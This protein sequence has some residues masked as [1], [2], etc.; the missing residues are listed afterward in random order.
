MTVRVVL[1]D[2]HSIVTTGLALLLAESDEV[3]VVGTATTA[4]EALDVIAATDPHV[5]LTDLSMP[6]MGGLELVRRLAAHRGG[7]RVLVLSATT[8]P[9]DL[10]SAIKGGASG[11]LVKDAPV[12]EIVAGIK[13]AAAG[14]MVV[15]SRVGAALALHLRQPEEESVL[16]E[17]EVEILTLVSLGLTN[18][19]ICQRLHLAEATVKTY[20]TRCYT[21]LDARDRASA[22]RVAIAKG[23]ID[24]T[25][26]D[27][28][29]L[30]GLRFPS[31]RRRRTG[32]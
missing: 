12:E 16:S 30:T 31:F 7:P 26:E 5:V 20:L 9:A 3:E 28:R 11:F 4:E 23:I 19:Q 27:V 21:K 18:G 14:E 6:G 25:R 15:S 24:P 13:G 8:K 32:R 29:D 10:A 2:D 17:R 1:V 22:V